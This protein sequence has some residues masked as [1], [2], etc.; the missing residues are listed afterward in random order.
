MSQISLY[1]FGSPRV[2]YAGRPISM[3][4]QKEMALLIYLVE[5]SREHTRMALATL[6]WPELDQSA[7]LAALRR[8]IYQL[9]SDVDEGLLEVTA[10]AVRLNPGVAV[11]RDTQQFLMAAHACASHQHPP[12]APMDSCLA[13]MREAIF[14]YTDDFLAGFSL[15]DCLNFDE[16]Q[17]FATEE[18]RAEY[19]R[20]VALLTTSYERLGDW[21][22]GAEMARLW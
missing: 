19:L 14:L 20:V 12:N 10:H 17:F 4:F 1:L 18:L 3:R 22:H 9:K 5:T 16:W 13:T 2:E 8:T 6:F 21:E 15:P 7:A 11:W